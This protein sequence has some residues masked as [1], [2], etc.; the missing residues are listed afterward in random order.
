MGAPLH[1]IFF[2]QP[3]LRK[4]QGLTLSI[5]EA[6]NRLQ[7]MMNELNLN[8]TVEIN[9]RRN[10]LDD[11]SVSGS[12]EVH[13]KHQCHII[14]SLTVPYRR[15]Q[16]TFSRDMIGMLVIILA[17][18]LRHRFQ[19]KKGAKFESNPLGKE[20]SKQYLHDYKP[21]NVTDYLCDPMELDAYAYEYATARHFNYK[22]AWIREYYERY[23]S[24][25]APARFIQFCLK[26][27]MKV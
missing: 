27:M 21:Q 17:H 26:I 12:A 10:R 6:R 19:W 14:L 15:R 1:T 9:R 20:R 5:I 11:V 23:V 8:V 25:Q 4:L 7:E 13:D 3:R 22:R 24:K 18:E 2:A 16:I